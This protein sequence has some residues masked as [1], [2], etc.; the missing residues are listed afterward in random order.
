MKSLLYLESEAVLY[1][2]DVS[3]VSVWETILEDILLYK[4][5]HRIQTT[6]QLQHALTG[7][8]RHVKPAHRGK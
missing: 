8:V 1:T 5:L 2:C 3:I 7:T 4:H 6:F